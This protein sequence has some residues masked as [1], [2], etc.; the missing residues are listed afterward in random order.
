MVKPL[1]SEKAVGKIL[2]SQSTKMPYEKA[3]V[4]E[5]PATNYHE[6]IN[7]PHDINPGDTVLIDP[8]FG[9]EINDLLITGYHKIIAKVKGE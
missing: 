1:G 3:I 7:I 6:C 8:E 5:I 4:I 2:L 9:Y